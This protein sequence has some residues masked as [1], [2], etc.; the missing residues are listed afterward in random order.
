MLPGR[1]IRSSALAGLLACVAIGGA[2]GASAAVPAMT[3][4][5][6]DAAVPSGSDARAGAS[7]R[8]Q[9][10]EE[11]IR[12]AVRDVAASYA[13][14]GAP[15]QLER[16][17]GGK[18]RDYVLGYRILESIGDR[19]ARTLRGRGGPKIEHAARLEVS[20]D[21]R[22][23]TSALAAAGLWSPESTGGVLPSSHFLLEAPLR[24]EAWT[25]LQAALLSAGADRVVPD[26]ITAEGMEVRVIGSRDPRRLLESIQRSRPDGLVLEGLFGTNPLRVR[27]R[28]QERD[29]PTSDQRT[30]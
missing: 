3:R 1:S 12:Q 8:Q 24:W 6:V 18:P 10:I 26:R 27:A 14:P 20:V 2:L 28:L 13:G 5:E 22:R 4:V 15:P 23:V 16:A 17:L 9:V 7:V 29:G 19:P 11:G 30:P 21:T 25:R